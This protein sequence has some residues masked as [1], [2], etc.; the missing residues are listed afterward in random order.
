MQNTLIE[1][2][3]LVESLGMRRGVPNPLAIWR[4]AKRLRHDRPD[5]VV[6]WMYNSN[7]LGALAALLTSIPLVW[8]VHHTEVHRGSCSFNTCFSD[9]WGVRLSHR[10]PA[11]IVFA[12]RASYRAHVDRGYSN[13]RSLVIP[14]GFDSQ[15]FQ[16]CPAACISVRRE[17]GL[18]ENCLLIGLIG[19]FHPDKDH[20]SFIRAA[21]Q[22]HDMQPDVNF[23]LCG[24]RIDPS[25]SQL[26]DWIEQAGIRER[27]HL[28]GVRND[29]PRLFASLDL[30]V[31]SS[32]TEAFPLTIGEAMYCGVPC[33]VT[34]VGD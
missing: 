5:L 16:P 29:M 15:V 33:V 6:S 3:V 30:N 31:S 28:L 23:L 24:P 7:L 14:N 18:P 32:I 26:I 9:R 8:N 27:C 13:D 2:G 19:R 25:N 11:K 21:Q 1:Q 22:I 12:S 4:L 10:L 34:D 17:L 20:A